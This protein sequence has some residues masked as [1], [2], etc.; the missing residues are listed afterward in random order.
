MK[1]LPP[2]LALVLLL[3]ACKPADKAGDALRRAQAYAQQGQFQK[4]LQEHVWFHNN[5]LQVDRSYYGVRLS[6]ALDDWVKLGSKYPPA[7]E[8]LKTIRDKKTSLLAGG[9]PNPELFHDVDAINE[10]LG[11][12][13]STAALFKQIDARN[14]AFAGSLYEIAE[15]SL[16]AAGEYPLARKYLGDPQA[17]FA[18]ATNNFQRGLVFAA[19]HLQN[20][21]IARKATEQIFSE[22][23]VRLL[24]V[25]DKT[26]NSPGARAIQTQALKL[27]DNDAIRNV[28]LR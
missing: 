19:N 3:C 20:G 17:R 28:P 1:P 26:G 22:R 6:F 13:R 9:D 24:T 2:I 18:T 27:L 12:T 14:P 11:D 8:E 7:L 15:Q 5:A 25:L 10:H 23:V 16:I 21:D 4:A